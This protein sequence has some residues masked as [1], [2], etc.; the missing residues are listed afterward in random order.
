MY[1]LDA[2][3][4]RPIEIIVVGGSALSL[5]KLKDRTKDIDLFIRGISYEEF[6]PILENLKIHYRF[7]KV[8]YW[9]NGKMILHKNGR[10]FEKRMPE[11][12][13]K[14]SKEITPPKPFKK[15]N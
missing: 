11:D 8:D 13:A 5:L 3:L 10:I 6:S 4:E 1:N 2:L 9:E 7:G 15:L 14:I 12:Y